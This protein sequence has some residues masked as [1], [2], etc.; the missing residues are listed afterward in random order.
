MSVARPSRAPRWAPVLLVPGGLALLAGLTLLALLGLL[1]LRGGHRLARVEHLLVAVDGLDGLRQRGGALGVVQAALVGTED[2]LA[3]T[4]RGLGEDHLEL[5]D[6]LLGRRAVDRDL[7]GDLGR[8]QRDR[9][10]QRHEQHQPREQDL[11]RVAVRGTADAVEK[12]GHRKNPS[13]KR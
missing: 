12:G 4:A 9:G 7:G 8:V 11:D 6:Q 3:L 13:N 5:V 1:L 2:D 10:A